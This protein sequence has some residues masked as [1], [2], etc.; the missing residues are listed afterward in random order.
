MRNSS[1]KI[2]NLSRFANVSGVSTLAK[3]L[4]NARA[5]GYVRV[6]NYHHVPID[7]LDHFEEQIDY[8]AREFAFADLAHLNGVLDGTIQVSTP[9]ILFTFDDGL[10]SHATH[11]ADL[12]TRKG[13]QGVFFVPTAAPDVPKELQRQ[14]AVDHQVARADENFVVNDRVFASWDSWKKVSD[15]HVVACHTHDHLRFEAS[16]SGA[17]VAQQLTSSFSKLEEHL[18][19]DTHQFCWVGGEKTSYSPQAVAAIRES[20]ATLSFTTC[21]LPVTKCTDPLRIERTNIES[22]F[23]INRVKLSVCG[24]VDARYSIKRRQLDA[25]FRHV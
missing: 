12:L 9:S 2:E 4:L 6:L 21:S 24:I 19:I 10:E 3:M 11:V 23:S 22:F 8:L 16:V 5:K 1:K 14:W 18:N 20:A 15:K 17:V 25:F 7:E 13:I